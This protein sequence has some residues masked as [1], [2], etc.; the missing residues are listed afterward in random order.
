[1]IFKKAKSDYIETMRW[2]VL[3]CVASS[4]ASEPS[5]ALQRLVDGNARYVEDQLSHP[6][7]SSDRREEITSGQAPFATIL[8]C[9]DSRVPPEIIFDQGLGDLFVVRVAG[10][11]VAPVEQDSIDYSVKYLGSS[12]IL[13]MGHESCG[14]VD[15]VMA[16]KTADIE[17]VARLIKPAIK[18]SKDI[19][20]A[21]KANVRWVV[22][23]VKKSP[24]IKKYMA[25]G[26]IDVVGGYY[27][28]GTGKVE[29]L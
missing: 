21:I 14:A 28:L 1:M 5:V 26:K 15:A 3:F 29:L 13:V 24:M 7:R 6:D 17:D 18:Q 12:I 16:G 25:D 22:N 4:V 8:G 2:F 10:N 20:S 9:S 27:H 19:E 11:V 23:S